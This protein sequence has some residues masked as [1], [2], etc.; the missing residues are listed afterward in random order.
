MMNNSAWTLAHACVESAWVCVSMFRCVWESE[1]P[2]PKRRLWKPLVGAATD[3]GGN[4]TCEPEPEPQAA[5][6]GNM[7]SAAAADADR[8]S[9]LQQAESVAVK[10][11]FQVKSQV[12][13]LRVT[14]WCRAPADTLMFVEPKPPTAHKLIRFCKIEWGH[15]KPHATSLW[16]SLY[17]LGRRKKDV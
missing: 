6:D 7:T 10:S 16:D 5:A 17:F 4:R 14:H 1:D 11:R 15:Y 9:A 12:S 3:N 13:S 8:R 2:D